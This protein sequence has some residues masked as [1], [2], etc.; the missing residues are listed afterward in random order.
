GALASN[1]GDAIE[2]LKYGD[3]AFTRVSASSVSAYV[4]QINAIQFPYLYKNSEHMWKVLNGDIGQTILGGIESSGSG[5]VGL[6]YYDAGSRNFYVTKPVYSVEDMKGL[7]IRVLGSPIMLDMCTAL[8]A[9]GVTGLSM[10]EV[11]GAIERNKIDGA[12]NNFPTY[13]SNG[14]YSIAPY[15]ILDQHTRVPEILI[16]SKKVL[17]RLDPKD[18]EIIKRVAK[19]TQEYEIQKWQEREA[20]SER[21]ARENGCTVIQLSDSTYSDFQKAMEPVYEKHGSKYMSIINSIRAL[22]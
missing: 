16:A 21:V 7:R 1:E 6:C 19:Q 13:Q 14:D 18:V 12:E 17:S 5:L 22:Q 20:Y 9:K 3:L 10:T 2:A 15:F 4:D 8:G 11:R